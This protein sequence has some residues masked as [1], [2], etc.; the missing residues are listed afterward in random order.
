[1]W[2]GEG[3]M[4]LGVKVKGTEKNAIIFCRDNR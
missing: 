2:T 3:M 4:S 1:M